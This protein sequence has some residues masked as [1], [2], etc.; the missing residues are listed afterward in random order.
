MEPKK[1]ETNTFDAISGEVRGT[2]WSVMGWLIL[3]VCAMYCICTVYSSPV[4]FL[5]RGEGP[6]DIQSMNFPNRDNCK[7]TGTQS[8]K[9]HDRKL[10]Q[11]LLITAGLYS[12]KLFGL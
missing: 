2:A 7:H 11:L 4:V 9:H 12:L 5:L 3:H 10:T 8:E 1:S 6:G